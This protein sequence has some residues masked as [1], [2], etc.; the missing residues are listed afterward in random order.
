MSKKPR[1]S[2]LM[3]TATTTSSNIVNALLRILRCPAVKGSKDPGN[4]ALIFITLII[5]CF[6]NIRVVMQIEVRTCSKVASPTHFYYVTLTLNPSPRERDLPSPSR[7]LI[8][9]IV[10]QISEH[11][12]NCQSMGVFPSDWRISLVLE[13]CRQPKNAPR[14]SGEGCAAS[15]T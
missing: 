14:A 8:I 1:L 9:I 5:N 10:P 6:A 2:W 3:P 11:D 7:A 13:K 4:N 12:Y 15:R